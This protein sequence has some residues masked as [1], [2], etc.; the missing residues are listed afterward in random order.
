MAALVEPV[1]LG[2]AD[3]V[4]GSRNLGRAEPGS[5][6]PQARFGNWLACHLMRLRWNSHFT[7]LGPFRAISRAA[8]DRLDMADPDYGWTVEMQIKALRA[9]LR[10]REVP[11]AYR[12]RVGVSKISGTIRGVVGAGTK[13]LYLIAR[14]GVM[15]GPPRHSE[16]RLH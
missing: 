10:C 16:E 15:P 9:G 11:V 5:L 3:L 14:F 1:A 4:I 13:I 12:R 7:D 2:Q 6:T 8:L